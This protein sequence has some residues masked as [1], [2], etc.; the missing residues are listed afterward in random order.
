MLGLLSTNSSSSYTLDFYNGGIETSR[1]V[2]QPKYQPAD[3]IDL[4]TSQAVTKGP[5]NAPRAISIPLGWTIGG[6]TAGIHGNSTKE[7][8]R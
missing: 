1:S 2:K 8:K 4:V 7:R 5:E 3:N 6:P